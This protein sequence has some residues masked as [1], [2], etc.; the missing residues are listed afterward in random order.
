MQEI[1]INNIKFSSFVKLNIVIQIALGIF[2][3]LIGLLI[4]FFSQNVY[5]NAGD[6]KITGILAGM[7]NLIFFPLTLGITG[8]FISIFAYFPFKYW[9]KIFGLR[10]F[11]MCESKD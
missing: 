6:F 8:I 7:I 11:T 1:K 5:F 2:V 3:G 10:I 9:V 4:S